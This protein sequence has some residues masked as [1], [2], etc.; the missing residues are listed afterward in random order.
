MQYPA[1]Y[2]L[3]IV[4]GQY[5]VTAGCPL[6]CICMS[7]KTYKLGLKFVKVCGML[8]RQ[9]YIANAATI[10]SRSTCQVTEQHSTMYPTLIAVY[11]SEYIVTQDFLLGLQ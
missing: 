6:G 1:G 5:L 8:M 11:A 7:S 2:P 4:A 10:V 3:S 9:A